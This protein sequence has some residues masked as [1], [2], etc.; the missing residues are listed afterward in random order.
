[1][2]PATKMAAKGT[3][4]RAARRTAANKGD[5]IFSLRH[6][7]AQLTLQLLLLYYGFDL[8]SRAIQK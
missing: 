7:L 2:T 3:Q 1:M 4:R 5:M 8:L 6:D